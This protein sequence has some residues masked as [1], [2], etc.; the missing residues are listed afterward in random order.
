[1][2]VQ[3]PEGLVRSVKALAQQSISQKS[4]RKI[5]TH[6]LQLR[7]SSGGCV[8]CP[9]DQQHQRCHWVSKH[10]SGVPTAAAPQS[11]SSGVGSTRGKLMLWI[12][13]FRIR[14]E[15]KSVYIGRRRDTP[16]FIPSDRLNIFISEGWNSYFSHVSF[17]MLFILKYIE[18]QYWIVIKY[19]R[20]W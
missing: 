8:L 3:V 20:L 18:M 15:R 17:F 5:V 14:V 16:L 10:R 1:M 2:S 6:E 12:L 9:K 13:I 19:G 4:T 11:G 7:E